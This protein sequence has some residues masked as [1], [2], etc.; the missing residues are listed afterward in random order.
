MS[1]QPFFNLRHSA[2][3]KNESLTYEEFLKVDKIKVLVLQALK[4]GCACLKV[5]NNRYTGRCFKNSKQYRFPLGFE[6]L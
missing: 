5:L 1:E 6:F 4:K 3:A 2:G